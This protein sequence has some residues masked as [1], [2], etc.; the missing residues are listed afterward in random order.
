[1]ETVEEI[2]CAQLDS[3]YQ[4]IQVKIDP[5]TAQACLLPALDAGGGIAKSQGG[6]N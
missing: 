2:L 5:S 6:F 4:K 1:M 3:V